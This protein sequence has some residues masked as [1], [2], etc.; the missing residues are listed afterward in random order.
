MNTIRVGIGGDLKAAIAQAQPEDVIELA[1]GARF[2][3][4]FVLPLKPSGGAAITI[5]SNAALPFR[6]I[7]PADKPL[8]PILSSGVNAP[9]LTAGAGVSG[10][11]FEG[12]CFEGTTGWGNGE[13]V[14]IQ[15]G[16]SMTFDRVLIQAPATGM[17][18]GIRGNGT[19]IRV[20]RSHIDGCWAM[21]QDSQAFCAW[22]GAGPYVLMDNFL[23]GAS[24]NFLFG[25]ANSSSPENI[26][27]DIWIANNDCTKR[28]AWRKPGTGFNV[29]NL[30]EL[31]SARRV[32]ILNNRFSGNWTDGQSG[33]GFLITVRND[34]GQS[35][36]SVIE[37]VRFE[38]NTLEDTERG[39]NILGRDSYQPSG[40]T[41]RIIVR[42]NTVR[43][44]GG[45]FL[46]A[47]GEVGELTVE[48][49]TT[50]A[51]VFFY[52]GEVWPAGEAKV[53]PALYAVDKLT[54]NRNTETSVGGDAV[55]NGEV[56]FKAYVRNAVW[57]GVTIVGTKPEPQPEPQPDPEPE[58]EPEDIVGPDVRI[59]VLSRQGKSHNFNVRADSAAVDVAKVEFF[60]NMQLRQTVTMAPY[61]T[62]L[63]LKGYR[64]DVTVL[65]KATDT[66]GNVGTASR[67]L[68]LA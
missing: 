39:I 67:T 61:A 28:E 5:R 65:A 55:G 26:P 58:P 51:H 2:V 35:P 31:K 30:G 52:S 11:R 1:A 36:W 66:A 13:A 46:Q 19:N 6:R 4:E 3:G 7:T 50:N 59:A 22:D 25:G 60:V 47:G 38:G 64:G 27:S 16:D 62:V 37:D 53:R 45:Y 63:P 42:N 34:E 18:R 15:G 23:E 54:M 43:T 40:R 10:W 9:I 41:T 8:L 56:A 21:G 29:K 17:K 48:D 49:N 44:T 33:A 14:V 32:V 57:N 68:V 20:L 12:I 24:E